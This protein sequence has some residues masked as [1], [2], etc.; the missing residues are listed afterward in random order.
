MDNKPPK[1]FVIASD[2]SGSR[3]IK[4]SSAAFHCVRSGN[5]FCNIAGVSLGGE[6]TSTFLAWATRASILLFH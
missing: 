4:G 2:G 1:A 3:E 6:L 5:N